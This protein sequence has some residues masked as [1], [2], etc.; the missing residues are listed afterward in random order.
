MA[1]QLWDGTGAFELGTIQRKGTDLRVS[2]I[3]DTL[4]S[5]DTCNRASLRLR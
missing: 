3:N 1:M 5:V 2:K 4:L